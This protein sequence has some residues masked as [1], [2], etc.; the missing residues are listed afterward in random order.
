MA[1]GY[2]LGG[3]SLRISKRPSERM[4]KALGFSAEEANDDQFGFSFLKPW[5]MV[6]HHAVV[7]LSVLTVLSTLAGE[8]N[9]RE[10]VAFPKNNRQPTQ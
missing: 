6:S 3:G 8:E 1:N 9:I 10:V 2:E 5:T 7:W 4:F